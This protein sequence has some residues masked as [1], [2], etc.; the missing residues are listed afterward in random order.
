MYSYTDNELA[1]SLVLLTDRFNV[2]TV[3]LDL[4]KHRVAVIYHFGFVI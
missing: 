4:I 2:P 1:I 3:L